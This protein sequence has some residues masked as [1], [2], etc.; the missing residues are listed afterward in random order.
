MRNAGYS[1]FQKRKIA[2]NPEIAMI[3]PKMKSKLMFDVTTI[4]R[5]T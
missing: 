1:P 2:T 5:K 3:N 4:E